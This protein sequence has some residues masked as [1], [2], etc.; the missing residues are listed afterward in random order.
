LQE[1]GDDD[2][3]DDVSCMIIDIHVS[4]SI[5]PRSFIFFVQDVFEDEVPGAVSE[6]GSWHSDIDD[7]DSEKP[8]VLVAKRPTKA[9]AGKK[10]TA[11]TVPSAPAKKIA[12]VSQNQVHT[13]SSSTVSHEDGALSAPVSVHMPA[14]PFEV[15]DDLWIDGVDED[16][17]ED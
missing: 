15:V 1:L 8:P 11:Q 7:S 4:F 12:P 10:A 6:D 3:K 14:V 17:G 2:G 16:Y 5:P 9:S 13:A